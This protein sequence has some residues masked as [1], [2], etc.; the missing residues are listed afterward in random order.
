[1]TVYLICGAGAAQQIVDQQIAGAAD[2]TAV[3]SSVHLPFWALLI[4]FGAAE[5]L[6]VHVHFRRSAHSMTPGDIPLVFGLLFASGHDVILAAA[7]GRLLVLA[8]HRKPP[9]IR[10]AFNFGQF[11]LGSCIAV[12]VFHA[13]VSEA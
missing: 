11:L 9:I 10:L 5:R 1:M 8:V 3:I 2:T 12:V 13:I 7:L 6:V 4:G